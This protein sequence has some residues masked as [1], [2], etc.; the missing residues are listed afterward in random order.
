ML[1]Q[2]KTKHPKICNCYTCMASLLS[3]KDTADHAE[4]LKSTMVDRKNPDNPDT[5]LLE[6]KAA[7]FI[8]KTGTSADIAAILGLTPSAFQKPAKSIHPEELKVHALWRDKNQEEVKTARNASVF[9]ALGVL[10]FDTPTLRIPKMNAAK[11]PSTFLKKYGAKLIPFHKPVKIDSTEHPS[12]RNL[13]LI[14]YNFNVQY[15]S[16]YVLKPNGGGGIFV[17]TH[18]FPQLFT[19]LSPQSS[20]ALIL[21]IHHGSDQYSFSAFKIPFGYTMKIKSMAIHGDSFFVGPYAIA[22][23]ETELADS[24]VMRQNTT[25]R[26]IQAVELNKIHSVFLNNDNDSTGTMTAEEIPGYRLTRL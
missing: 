16:D 17:E 10:L 24:V 25:H 22:L 7:R 5:S 19:P 8:L 23:N 15:V 2:Q 12:L 6:S 9:G 11:V 20:G 21:G 4:Q 13:Y 18:P 3:E 14:E 1:H 26:E